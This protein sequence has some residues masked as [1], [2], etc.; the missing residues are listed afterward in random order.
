MKPLTLQELFDNAWQHFV[1]EGHLTSIVG[2]VCR[3]RTSDG[4]KCI[5]GVSIP[6]DLYSPYLEGVGAQVFN[7]DDAMEYVTAAQAAAAVR[8]QPLFEGLHFNALSEFQTV[9]DNLARSRNWTEEDIP[10]LQEA[11]K[12]DLIQFATKWDLQIPITS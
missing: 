5:V 10:E 8:V 6:E 3:Y 2:E 1:V 7:N 4:R 9:H 12:R 11:F